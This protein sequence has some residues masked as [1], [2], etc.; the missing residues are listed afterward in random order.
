MLS[1]GAGIVGGSV[2][3][4]CINTTVSYF[5]GGKKKK[6]AFFEVHCTQHCQEAQMGGFLTKKV[7][8]EL[9]FFFA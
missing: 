1:S 8:P 4:A 3:G 2:G 9:D 7:P 5:F 6:I